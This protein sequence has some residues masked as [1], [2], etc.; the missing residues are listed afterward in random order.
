M[1]KTEK[2]FDVDVVVLIFVCC[3]LCCRDM[4]SPEAHKC[5]QQSS[6]K[7]VS[8]AEVLA[9]NSQL[10]GKRGRP[11]YRVRTALTP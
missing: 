7:V 9:L 11:F 3:C 8:N 5:R 10:R 6:L 4:L 1:Q 2:Y